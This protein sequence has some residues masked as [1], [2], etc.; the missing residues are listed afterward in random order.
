MIAF[1]KFLNEIS[2]LK[3][4]LFCFHASQPTIFIASI[5]KLLICCFYLKID[6][7]QYF[8]AVLQLTFCFKILL[9]RKICILNMELKNS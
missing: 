2:F 6:L 4:I 3:Q 5:I 7:I 8:V 9:I 1:I